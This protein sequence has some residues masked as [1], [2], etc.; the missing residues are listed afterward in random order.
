MPSDDDAGSCLD[1][2]WA[3]NAQSEETKVAS[4]TVST[5]ADLPRDVFTPAPVTAREGDV[6]ASGVLVDLPR[7]VFTPDPAAISHKPLVSNELR[8]AVIQRTVK[9]RAP[10]ADFAG[11]DAA[12]IERSKLAAAVRVFDHCDCMFTRE[13]ADYRRKA[14]RTAQPRPISSA[15]KP[16]GCRFDPKSGVC[17]GQRFDRARRGRARV[18]GPQLAGSTSGHG[19]RAPGFGCFRLGG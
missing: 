13:P 10:P 3:W 12:R 4:P 5:L 8:P 1:G 18:I 6:P 14:S 9:T 2:E 16:A 17:M 7:D 15:G 19:L 11:R